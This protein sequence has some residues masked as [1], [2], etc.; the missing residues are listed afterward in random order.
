MRTR[1][2]DPHS[3]KVRGRG[4]G[5]APEGMKVKLRRAERRVLFRYR[6]EVRTRPGQ[7]PC[8]PRFHNCHRLNL[9][10]VGKQFDDVVPLKE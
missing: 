1:I 9:K 10:P 3:E 6:C 2:I 4:E 5:C 8:S 7:W